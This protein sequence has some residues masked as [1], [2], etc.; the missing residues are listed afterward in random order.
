MAEN[1]LAI[2]FLAV[3]TDNLIIGMEFRQSEKFLSKI[4]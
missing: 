3:L 1:S 4:Q 2:T